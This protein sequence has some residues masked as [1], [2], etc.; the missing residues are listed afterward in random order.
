MKKKKRRQF[1]APQAGGTREHAELPTSTADADFTIDIAKL[2]SPAKAYDADVGWIEYRPG[3][4]S[5]FFAK[6]DRDT[7][8]QLKSRLEIRYTP[9]NLIRTFW[10]I[11]EPFL[12]RLR[13]YV[14]NWS[15]EAQRTIDPIPSTT[16]A[17]QS[18]SEWASLTYM[19]HSGSAAAFDFY[20]ISPSVLAR[21]ARS[22]DSSLL[23]LR[24][25]VRVQ[26]STFE[27]LSLIERVRPVV[28]QIL[29]DL[30]KRHLDEM[31]GR[32]SGERPVPDGKQFDQKREYGS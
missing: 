12:D 25:V 17:V 22:A 23:K 6:L 19:S 3:N 4:V 8:T 9:E 18:H 2:E 5:L 13:D 1:V 29:R 15:P 21:Y 7:P 24:G 20:F 10:N 14:S 31:E 32:E 27:M 28:E 11:S 16:S 30:P 26:I